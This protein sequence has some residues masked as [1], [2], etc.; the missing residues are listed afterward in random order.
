MQGAETKGLFQNLG[1]EDLGSTG[2]E[3]GQEGGLSTCLAP[4]QTPSFPNTRESRS[5]QHCSS[6]SPD[7][8]AVFLDFIK[9]GSR[10]GLQSF[11]TS[12][13]EQSGS[14]NFILC[15]KKIT[16]KFKFFKKSR[17]ESDL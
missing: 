2:A 12:V 6:F 10:R 8:V 1:K 3:G 7:G 5:L 4:V 14:L 9:H 16:G 17:D 13:P 15:D 11:I